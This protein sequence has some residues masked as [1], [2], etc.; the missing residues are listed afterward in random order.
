MKTIM[1]WQSVLRNRRRPPRPSSKLSTSVYLSIILRLTQSVSQPRSLSWLGLLGDT[2][3]IRGYDSGNPVAFEI[4]A[5]HGTQ[6]AMHIGAW[7]GGGTCRGIS[8]HANQ[9]CRDP[10]TAQWAHGLRSSVYIIKRITAAGRE[11]GL[12]WKPALAEA[13]SRFPRCSWQRITAPLTISF[14]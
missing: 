12:L 13:G 2:W 11:P 5:R 4:T 10:I 1:N 3:C 6:R 7:T 8:T 14:L 9:Q